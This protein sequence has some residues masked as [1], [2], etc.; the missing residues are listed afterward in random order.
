MPT[1]EIIDL[2]V[3]YPG[4][5]HPVR[6]L[7]GLNASIQDGDLAL[8][9]GPSGC[10]KTT[11]LSCIGGLQRPTSGQVVISGKPLDV[12]DEA[13]MVAHRQQAVGF[14]FQAFNLV[15]SLTVLDNVAAPLRTT[16]V[17]TR[18][19]RKRAGDLLERVGLGHRIRHR[20][21][22]LS[23]GQQQRVAI[24]RSLAH[25]PPIL[26]ADEPTANLDYTQVESVLA[27]LRDL[28]T[29]GRT[30]IISTHDDRLLP[31]AHRVVRM[32]PDVEDDAEG[33]PVHLVAGDTLF[34]TGD[35]GDLVY[36]VDEGFLEVVI[37][38]GDTMTVVA[39][40]GPGSYVGELGPMMGQ[41]RS[42][43]VRAATDAKVTGMSL[44]EFR[45]RS[46]SAVV[47]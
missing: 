35:P 32:R 46:R 19:A 6:A 34:A 36:F 44:Q 26:L 31:L 39:D 42:A 30:V 11:L 5:Q 25:D 22:Q 45:A 13:S 17:P 9:L 27:L 7:D 23:G 4:T 33:G 24:A 2:V 8:L 14:V 37:E 28:A 3:E 21:G 40:R 47:G 16:G 1:V 29:P 43:T 20:P 38:D 41:R 10:G 18:A 12:R 15:P